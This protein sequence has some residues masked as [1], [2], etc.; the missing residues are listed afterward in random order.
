M[1]QGVGCELQARDTH[2]R[3]GLDTFSKGPQQRLA[4]GVSRGLRVEKGQPGEQRTALLLRNC[5]CELLSFS[6]KNPQKSSQ[7]KS[8]AESRE[9]WYEKNNSLLPK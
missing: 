9:L 3:T 5:K 4:G 7:E 2:L 6:A 1:E 8:T